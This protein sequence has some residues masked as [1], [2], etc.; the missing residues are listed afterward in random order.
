MPVNYVTPAADQLFPVAGIRLGTAEAEIR[1]KSRRD[2]T[3][4]ALDDG[5]TVAGVFTQNRFCA[6][7]VQLCRDHLAGGKG[8]R[9][10]VI[11][12]GIA[13][14]GTGEP[15]MLAARETCDA[16]GKLLGIGAEQVL[17][18]SPA[19]FSSRSRSIV[20]RRGCPLRWPTSRPTTG[21]PRRTPS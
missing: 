1:K 15:G 20:S 11:N 10:L 12:T 8:I 19:S 17:P 4:V 7:P 9:A 2:L 13:N 3:L 14:A 6:A 5:C 21:M 18:F 16:V